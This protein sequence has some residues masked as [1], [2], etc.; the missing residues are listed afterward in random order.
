MVKS[1][2]A[3]R[4]E[5]PRAKKFKQERRH[6][7]PRRAF[8]QGSECQ[9]HNAT[10]PLKGIEGCYRYAPRTDPPTLNVFPGTSIKFNHY[11][12]IIITNLSHTILHIRH[13]ISC[14]RP[15]TITV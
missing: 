4:V 6:S 8:S 10:N 5:Y 14:R 12:V 2:S 15:L 9:I 3:L 11:L 1:R 7:L 13:A